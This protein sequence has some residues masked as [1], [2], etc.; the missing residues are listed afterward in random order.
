MQLAKDNFAVLIDYWAVDW[1]YDGCTFRSSWQAFRGNSRKARTVPM[2]ATA[3][4]E[5]KKTRTIAVR[6]VDVFGNDAGVT[7]EV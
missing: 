7:V 2:E 3:T 6:V 5:K 1:D 4:L